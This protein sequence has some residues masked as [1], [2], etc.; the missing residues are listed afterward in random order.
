VDVNGL[1]AEEVCEML[2]THAWKIES[3]KHQSTGLYLAVIC[4]NCGAESIISAH[5][6]KRPGYE[7]LLEEQVHD[8]E[9][10]RSLVSEIKRPDPEFSINRKFSSLE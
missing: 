10:G 3:V 7:T 4:K 5:S 6:I 1:D 9:S 8:R 2:S